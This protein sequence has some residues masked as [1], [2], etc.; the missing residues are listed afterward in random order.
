MNN[1]AKLFCFW[2]ILSVIGCFL[3]TTAW[4]DS[5]KIENTDNGHFYQRIDTEMTWSEAKNYCEGLLGYLATI[6]SQDENDFIVNNIPLTSYHIWLGG[7]DEAQEGAW[8]WITGEAW[9]YT[10]WDQYEPND[11]LG[12]DY[13]EIRSTGKW[14]DHGLPSQDNEHIFICEWD[15]SIDIAIDIKPDSDPNCFNINGNGVIPVAILG[16]ADFDVYDIDQSSLL[17]GGLSVRVRGNKGPL[18]HIED[19][20]NDS[21][22]DLVCQFE[23][24]ASNWIAGDTTATLTGNLSD[25]R[26]IEG[27]DYICVVP[28][29]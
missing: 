10:N 1:S 4:A 7:T 14:N 12:E 16:S 29:E 26:A 15:S 22:L 17:F 9:S 3:F 18:C 8:E 6:T 11:Y 27:T 13:L 24:D 20:N 23:D 19:T 2:T 21:F 28:P 5:E 25:G